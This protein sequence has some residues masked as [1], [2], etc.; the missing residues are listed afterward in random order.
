MDLDFN[1]SISPLSTWTLP[2]DPAYL[3]SQDE[4]RNLLFTTAQTPAPTRR[5]SPV[6]EHTARAEAS[7]S[8][9]VR[10]ILCHGRRLEYLNNYIDCVAPWLDMFDS[11]RSFAI[12]LPLIY[13]NCPA[14]LY[15][16]LAISAR[17]MELKEGIK[18]PCDS[19]E[20]YQEAIRLLKPLL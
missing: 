1:A 9:V 18:N 8:D 5:G 10:Q 4:L 15:A 20:L 7:T 3:A 11:Y 19:L 6:I 13:Q 2:L 12:R 14:V 17:Q 16:I